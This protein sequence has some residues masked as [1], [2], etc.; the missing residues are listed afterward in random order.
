MPTSTGRFAVDAGGGFRLYVPPDVIARPASAS[1]VQVSTMGVG[2]GSDD[3]FRLYQPPLVIPEPEPDPPVNL[4]LPIAQA[5]GGPIEGNMAICSTGTW[6]GGVPR[7][8]AYQW[9]VVLGAA[10]PGATANSWTISGY[11]GEMVECQV[12]ATNS[13]GSATAVSNAIGP[14]E[15]AAPPEE[16]PAA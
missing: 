1:G 4:T 6:S 2:L 7:T 15:A 9:Y 5:V 14:I 16:P 8:Y 11:E 13:D 12:T 10:I 3:K